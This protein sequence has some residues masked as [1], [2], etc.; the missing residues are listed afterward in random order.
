[1]SLVPARDSVSGVPICT[2]VEELYR[3]GGDMRELF[4]QMGC[5]A[6]RR[7]GVLGLLPGVGDGCIISGR[8]DNWCAAR[9]IG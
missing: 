3:C 8:G 4:W 7:V 5:K 1:M 6:V 2:A 9:V